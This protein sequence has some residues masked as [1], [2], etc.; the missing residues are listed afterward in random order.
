MH[1]EVVTLFPELVAQV[2][3]FGVVGADWNAGCCGS[4]RS[5]RASLRRIRIARWTTARMAA[6][7]GC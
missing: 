7:R 2:G 6:D 3:R 4:G 1:F 5:I